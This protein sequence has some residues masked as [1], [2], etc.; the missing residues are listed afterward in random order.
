VRDAQNAICD[1]LRALS[2]QRYMAAMW[3]LGTELTTLYEGQLSEPEKSLAEST[4]AIVSDVAI[5]GDPARQ[6]LQAA[7][8]ATRWGQAIADDEPHASGG[9]LNTWITFEGVAAEITGTSAPF[10]AAD[11]V[12][13]AA[14]RRWRDPNRWADG[15]SIRTR[16]SQTTRRWL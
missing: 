1:G 7:E 14:V 5:S 11:W 8:L 2:W 13:G 10:Y 4:L 6:K 16:R 15:G 3:I 9:L 12:V